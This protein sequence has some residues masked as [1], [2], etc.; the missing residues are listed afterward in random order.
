VRDQFIARFALP[1]DGK[2]VVFAM[3]LK[4]NKRPWMETLLS[5]A[6]GLATSRLDVQIIIAGEG[7]LLPEL[8]TRAARIFSSS[9]GK[10]VVCPIGPVFET[11]D[12]VQ[13]YNY[14]DV[15]AGTGRGILE[16]MACGKP[17]IILGENC[18][19]QIL[20]A[21]NVAA[22]AHTNFSGRHF[23]RHAEDLRPLPELFSTLLTDEVALAEGRRLSESYIS[24]E[25]DARLGA[26]QLAQIYRQASDDPARLVE[27][28]SWMA[29]YVAEWVTRGL[30]RRL[31]RLAGRRG[32]G[33]SAKFYS[34]GPMLK[35]EGRSER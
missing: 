28:N 18:E 24:Q 20:D 17:A 21:D 23:R 6:E 25:M 11:A 12:L 16:A 10:P 33:G 8:R 31:G 27:F 35:A 4:E 19:G 9:T 26:E 30:G 1:R 15:I 5:A 2:R 29:R 7:E 34:K 13:L 32:R 3:R 22:A 14:A